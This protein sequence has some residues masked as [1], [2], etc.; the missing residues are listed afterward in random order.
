MTAHESL[1]RMLNNMTSQDDER[2]FVRY[3]T[4]EQ[5]PTLQ[6]RAC[7][8]MLQCMVEWG[9]NKF[10]DDRNRMT[11]LIGKD[12]REYLEQKGVLI[13]KPDGAETVYLPFI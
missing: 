5:H 12:I 7:R 13:P 4:K 8:L 11:Q 1:S 3:W 9:K 10:V 2:E 6:Q